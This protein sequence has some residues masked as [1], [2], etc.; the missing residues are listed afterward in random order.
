M[1]LLFSSQWILGDLRSSC[2]PLRFL[3]I[4]SHK[5]FYW[6]IWFWSVF[7]CYLQV[8]RILD[9]FNIFWHENTWSL[10]GRTQTQSSWG[11]SCFN[12]SI[13]FVTP[14]LSGLGLITGQ[15]LSLTTSNSSY[16]GSSGYGGYG[17]NVTVIVTANGGAATATGGAATA[18]GGSNTNNDNDTNTA[19]NTGRKMKNELERLVKLFLRLLQTMPGAFQ[20][21][22]FT[23]LSD[24]DRWCDRSLSHFY[25]V[26]KILSIKSQ[27]CEICKL[28]SNCLNVDH[29]FSLQWFWIV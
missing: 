4:C 8:P 23:R 21:W 19:T 10:F 28:C 20:W 26:V 22:L 12:E 16:Y 29:S 15:L 27:H 9:F 18:T 5:S 3:W 11:R 14:F 13:L 6:L 25:L 7:L 17:N 1:I 24:C 2:P